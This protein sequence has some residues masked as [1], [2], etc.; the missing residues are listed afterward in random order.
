MSS[1]TLKS[2]QSQNQ[3]DLRQKLSRD[4]LQGTG[5]LDLLHIS[6]FSKV[7]SPRHVNENPELSTY[8][9][10]KHQGADFAPNALPAIILQSSTFLVLSYVVTSIHVLLNLLFVKRQ[11]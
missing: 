9:P 4:I 1:I 2:F 10:L 11:Y 5:T 7:S 8:L 6:I 3:S